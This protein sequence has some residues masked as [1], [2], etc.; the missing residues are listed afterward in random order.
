MTNLKL[1]F[2]MHLIKQLEMATKDYVAYLHNDIIL[3][4]NFCEN[5]LKHCNG[6]T[7][8]SYTTIEP[9][10]FAGHV[11]PGKI[12]RDFGTELSNTKFDEIQQFSLDQQ[13]IDKDKTEPGITFFM[14]LSREVLTNL[15]GLD[16]TFNPMFCEDDDLI[17]R[18]K[19][20]GMKML[21][22]LDAICYH[23][24]SKTS[25]FSEEFKERTR[26]I[27]HNS[28]RNFLRKWGFRH[29]RHNA[30]YKIYYHVRN[31]SLWLLENLEPW[32]D[33][34]YVDIDP[35]SY[36]EK[37]Q[38]NTSFD[39]KRRIYNHGDRSD[40][41]GIHVKF[42]ASKLTQNSINILQSLPDI[43]FETNETGQFQ[44]DIFDINISTIANYSNLLVK[45]RL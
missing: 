27:E 34:I 18:L 25:R 36:I 44:I 7:V 13:K 29:S 37:E 15:G 11:R 19:L 24:V 21:T 23:Y 31:C 4:P 17:L 39:L 40:P 38:P 2:Q 35:S 10:I 45:K 28:N 43:I 42:D 1:H 30:S 5:L 3:T 9:P 26:Q 33:N 12:I 14:C 22:S 6:S 16:P 32:C 20:F 8:V 41:N